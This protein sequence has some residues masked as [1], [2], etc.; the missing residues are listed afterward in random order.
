MTVTLTDVFRNF[1]AEHAEEFEGAPAMHGG[2]HN[3]KYYELFNVYLKLYENTL[4]NYLNTLDVPIDE[5]YKEVREAQEETEDPYIRTFVDCLLASTDYDSFYKVMAREGN[6]SLSMK[7]MGIKSPTKAES[8]TAESKDSR[9]DDKK[10]SSRDADDGE[11]KS[12][13]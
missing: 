13:K 8:K 12:A 3:L 4:E 10:G 7:K 2:E 9:C 6:R 5:F 1:F 11:K